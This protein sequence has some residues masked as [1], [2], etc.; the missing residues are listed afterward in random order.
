MTDGVVF[1]SVAF[2]RHRVAAAVLTGLALVGH[3][4]LPELPPDGELV[5]LVVAVALL[6]VPHGAVDHLVAKPFFAGRWQRVWLPVFG[7]C[8]VG[9]AALVVLLWLLAP[10]VSLAG[11]LLLSILHFGAGDQRDGL[12]ALASGSLVVLGPVAVHPADCATL[13]APLAGRSGDAMAGL[14]E[15]LQPLLLATVALALLPFVVRSL[16]RRCWAILAELGLL[17]TTVALLPPL[18]AFVLYFCI[19]HAPRHVLEIAQS[20]APGSTRLGLRRFV[21]AALPFSALTIAGGALAWASVASLR[22]PSDAT[23]QVIF[24]GLAALTVPHMI[25]MSAASRGGDQLALS[26][27]T[28]PARSRARRAPPRP[29]PG[30]SPRP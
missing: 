14:L 9:L 19:W 27:T 5:L 7:L 23:L 25:V 1:G 11:F 13:F 16:R 10:G 3:G 20:F 24:I 6:G 8:Y 17:A 29:V 21:W 2:A 4:L 30:C 26:A 18:Q 28:A 15:G 12:G 22:S